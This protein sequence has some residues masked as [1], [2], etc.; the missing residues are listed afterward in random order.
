MS[1][2][3][4]RPLD[5]GEEIHVGDTL[6]AHRKFNVATAYAVM[7]GNINVAVFGPAGLQYHHTDDGLVREPCLSLGAAIDRIRF[8]V[9]GKSL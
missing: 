5:E 3:W 1:H 2:Y 8:L 4:I 9:D 6:V 7:R